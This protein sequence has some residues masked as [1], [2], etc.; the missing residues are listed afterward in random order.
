MVQSI[1]D[2]LSIIKVPLVEGL[3]SSTQNHGAN[4]NILDGTGA[5]WLLGKILN[6][7]LSSGEGAC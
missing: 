3:L 2:K 1:L 5:C 4:I 7:E 6:D